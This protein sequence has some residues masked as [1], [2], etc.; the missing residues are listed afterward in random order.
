MTNRNNANQPNR[1]PD[2]PINR[3]VNNRAKQ[4][5]VPKN[6][7]GGV[8]PSQVAKPRNNMGVNPG[9]HN[10]AV[11]INN[12]QNPQV[13]NMPNPRFINNTNSRTANDSKIKADK[14]MNPGTGKKTASGYSND[15]KPN[16]NKKKK[17]QDRT[18]YL[19]YV[20]SAIA[21]I[22]L[23]VTVIHFMKDRAPI[24]EDDVTKAVS[25]TTKTELVTEVEEEVIASNIYFGGISLGGMEYADFEKQMTEKSSDILKN[26]KIN[27]ENEKDEDN[28]KKSSF[29][30]LELGVGLDL[31]KIY[32]NAEKLT[33]LLKQSP[34]NKASLF[35]YIVN[36]ETIEGTTS[37]PIEASSQITD[38]AEVNENKYTL[39]PIF[40]VDQVA[41]KKAVE[42]FA[43]E[44]E[45]KPGKLTAKSFN[46]ETLEFEF[47]EGTKG[48]KLD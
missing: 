43:A 19:V 6:R 31:E 34:G 41:L 25:K 36:A 27:L 14:S 33:D 7:Q 8:R 22:L 38:L 16:S 44:V 20:L 47:G 2:K 17:K 3:Q 39:H 40:T 21:L 26:I 37:D 9:S 46:L 4:N 13:R 48:Y 5:V 23:V 12:G 28:Q 29:N 45:I 35:L 15:R 1:K 11:R 30:A 24:S 42:D 10:G 32:Q 18:L